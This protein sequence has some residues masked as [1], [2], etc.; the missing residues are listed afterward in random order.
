MKIIDTHAHIFPEKIAQKAV[1]SISAF[2]GGTPMRHAG[3]AE[4]LLASGEAVG[5][6]KYLV[7]STA[8][9]PEQVEAINNFILEACAAHSQ[10]I[11]LGTMHPG[12]A[13]FEEELARIRAQGIK[14]IKLHPDFQRFNLDD[15]RMEPVFDALVQNGM[16]LLTHSGDHRYDFSHPGRIARVAERFPR[17]PIIAAHFGGWQQWEEARACL[18]LPN[19]YV[20]TS[21]TIPFAGGDAARKGLKAFGSDH[22]FF[23]TDFPMF[24]H[25]ES[26]ETLL[27]LGLPERELENILYNNFTALYGSLK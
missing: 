23:G 24:D 25:K 2:Y 22:V 10:F 15:A 20:D 12:Y 11:G 21:S 8:T 3:T 16:F 26:L 6:E 7:S 19:V 13:H 18:Q 27:E 4:A 5:V 9:K 1:E 14:G 17:L